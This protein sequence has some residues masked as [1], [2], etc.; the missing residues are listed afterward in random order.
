MIRYA[1]AAVAVT[2]AVVVAAG[3][4]DAHVLRPTW[5]TAAE[6]PW[7]L[8]EISVQRARAQ[9]CRAELDGGRWPVSKATPLGPL[10]RRWI[11]RLWR[12]R[13]AGCRADLSYLRTHPVRAI[14][15]VFGPT[16]GPGAV[17]VS[18]CETGGTFYV[19]A[20]NGQYLGLFQMG[21][22]ERAIYGHGSDALSQ[23][24]AAHRYFVASGRD[25]SP[26]ACKP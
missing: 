1:L 3:V 22:S 11:I 15:A 16:Y 14:L 7:R 25:W 19:G 2:V 5:A 18:R 13:V 12:G 20:K 9:S 24:R 4:R 6:Q 21:S 26:W 17:E 23:A 8:K 10:Y